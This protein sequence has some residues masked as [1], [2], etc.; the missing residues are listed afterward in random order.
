MQHINHIYPQA[1]G[2][3][4]NGHIRDD[5]GNACILFGLRIARLPF[6]GP[7]QSPLPP[8]TLGPARHQRQ[9]FAKNSP[10][11]LLGHGHRRLVYVVHFRSGKVRC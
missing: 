4:R 2:G 5:T 11:M 10:R 3:P 7:V 6:T 8:S 1:R 9:I